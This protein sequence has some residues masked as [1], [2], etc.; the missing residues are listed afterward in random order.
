[1]KLNAGSIKKELLE[2]IDADLKPQDFSGLFKAGKIL[3][4]I[5]FEDGSYKFYFRKFKKDYVFTVKKKD[6]VIIPECFVKGKHNFLAYYYNNPMPIKFA[7]V[8]SKVKS[9]AISNVYIDSTT[10]Y[11][12]LNTS[13]MSKWYG[14]MKLTPKSIIIILIVAAVLILIFLQVFGVVDVIGGL[15]GTL[16]KIK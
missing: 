15:Q 6:Y 10:L 8:S 16:Q 12:A 3:I 9:S 5:I 1:M 7:H 13:V 4:M 14:G 11:N 2:G